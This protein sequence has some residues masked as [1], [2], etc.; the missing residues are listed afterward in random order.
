MKRS[1]YAIAALL[2]GAMLATALLVD[3]GYIAVAVPG[4]L[5]T[6]SLP[7]FA[8]LL[9]L[10]YYVARLLWRNGKRPIII[11]TVDASAMHL[12]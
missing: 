9:I 4:H 7:A 1:L 2:I 8:L 11:V 5:L 6:L 10:A 12:S 3:P